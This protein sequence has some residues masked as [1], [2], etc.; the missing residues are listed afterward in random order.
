MELRQLAYFLAAA[1]TQNFSQAANLCLV[2]QPALSRQIAA[3]EREV[4][5][6]LFKRDKQRVKLTIAG[7]EFVTY[8]KAALDAAQQGQLMLVK[9]QEGFE[10]TVLVG[11]IASL[12]T[13]LLP[14]VFAAYHQRY[15]SVR[16]QVKVSKAE[17]LV[18]LVEEEKIDLGLTFDPVI[19]SDIVVVKELFRQPLQALVPIDHPL[20]HVDPA[21]LTLERVVAE[22]LIMLDAD[23]RVRKVAEQLLYQRGLMVQPIIEMDSLEGLKELIKLG[24]GIALIPPSLLR[25]SPD[26]IFL[27][28]CD[29]KE[30]FSFSLIYRRFGD[31]PR[32]AL[33]LI[34]LML[35]RPQQF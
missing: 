20:T 6:L 8:A 27:P 31:L 12:A 13:A 24:C 9:L 4:G 18:H 1:Q 35:E 25:L 19:Q 28:V 7:Q 2:A 26:L 23:S 5:V 29:L 3:L 10:G 17:Q 32:S 30:E 11:S 16:L 14:P 15:P 21:T 33:Q 22:P 34:N